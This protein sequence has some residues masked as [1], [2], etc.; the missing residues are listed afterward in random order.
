MHFTECLLSAKQAQINQQK[1]VN[2]YSID[3]HL[4]HSRKKSM[5]I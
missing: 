4:K 2:I 1:K 5:D 3:W